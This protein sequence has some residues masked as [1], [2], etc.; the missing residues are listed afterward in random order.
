ML[1]S[2]KSQYSLYSLPFSSSRSGHSV[3]PS[4]DDVLSGREQSKESTEA[5]AIRKRDARNLQ[6]FRDRIPGVAENRYRDDDIRKLKLGLQVETRKWRAEAAKLMRTRGQQYSVGVNSND[7]Q[8][9]D[10]GTSTRNAA[11]ATDL[12]SPADDW[13]SRFRPLAFDPPIEGQGQGVGKG[14]GAVAGSV[15]NSASRQ[16][17]QHQRA[18][19]GRWRASLELI[20]SARARGVGVGTEDPNMESDL[21][22]DEAEA[23]SVLKRGGTGGSWGGLGESD[24]ASTNYALLI[25]SCLL[26]SLSTYNLKV[27]NQ[28]QCRHYLH[29]FSTILLF[30]SFSLF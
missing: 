10:E 27:V 4:V 30:I 13:N 16:R 21:D 3:D 22:A 24:A 12:N 19:G 5:E 11:A 1:K 29:V 25:H 18:S 6:F 17:R 8:W 15:S 26:L 7:K 28:A 20:D 23:E 9:M 14:P 2:N